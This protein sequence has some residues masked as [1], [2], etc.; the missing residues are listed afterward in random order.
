MSDPVL[1]DEMGMEDDLVDVQNGLDD[2]F[3]EMEEGIGSLARQRQVGL[4][5]L[6][7]SRKRSVSMGELTAFD[8]AGRSSLSLR[9]G[10]H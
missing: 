3:L 2:N 6:L 9:S 7:L 8:C 5:V 1:P 4:L 10:R